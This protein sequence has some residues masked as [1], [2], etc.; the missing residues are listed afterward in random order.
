MNDKDPNGTDQHAP[1][2]KLDAGKA[3]IGTMC[4]GYFPNALAGVAELSAFGAK[5]YT[6]FGW[7]AVPNGIAR[8]TDGLVRH[9]SSEMRGEYSDSETELPHAYATA[10]NALARLELMLR[11]KKGITN[12]ELPEW[13]MEK[14]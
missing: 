14:K 7:A 4:L 12:N 13:L 11:E 9:L 6:P 3:P 1:G 10:W 5:K 8:Y 2:A